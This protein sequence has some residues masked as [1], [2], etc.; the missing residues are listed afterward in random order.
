[1]KNKFILASILFMTKST[2]ASNTDVN[3]LVKFLDGKWDN[4]SFEISNGKPVKKEEYPET[5]LIK[6]ADTITI[7][8]H[9]I[10]DGKDITKDME[11]EVSGKN[12]T[13]RQGPFKATGTREDSLY[14]MV[15]VFEGTEY[16]FRL[17]TLGDKYVFHRETW[18]DGKIQQ[19]DM[20]YLIRK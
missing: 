18:K 3:D 11:L 12:V 4:I 14:S 5:M 13:M 15:G 8:A 7:T 20:S 1:M 2:F 16:R 9:G 19:I 6:D 17:Y 10:R